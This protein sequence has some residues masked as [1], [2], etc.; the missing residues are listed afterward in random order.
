MYWFIVV[1]FKA[2]GIES[3]KDF[4]ARIADQCTPYLRCIRNDFFSGTL[5]EH[6]A[7]RPRSGRKVPNTFSKLLLVLQDDAVAEQ[8]EVLDWDER[9]LKATANGNSTTTTTLRRD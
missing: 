3:S 2:T 5:F 8:Q 1:V 6:S 9:F 4:S 7:A